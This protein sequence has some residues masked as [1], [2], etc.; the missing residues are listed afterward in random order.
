MRLSGLPV[1]LE[2][3]KAFNDAWQNTFDKVS[4]KYGHDMQKVHTILERYD[5]LLRAKYKNVTDWQ[6]MKT[7]K[8]WSDKLD[9]YGPI[10]VA[11][12]QG[13]GD[14]LYIIADQNLG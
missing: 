13:T 14:I 5:S 11:K 9:Q 6:E 7:K 4:E 2:A 10:L 3:Y 12:E 8:Q 1:D